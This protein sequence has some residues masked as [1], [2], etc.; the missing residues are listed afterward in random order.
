[1]GIKYLQVAS[2][3]TRRSI[4]KGILQSKIDKIKSFV[5]LDASSFG[6]NKFDIYN[7]T[8]RNGRFWESDNYENSTFSIIFNK[9]V[10][11]LH[12]IS[13]HSCEVSEC[14]A[15]F[16]VAGSNNGNSWEPICSIRRTNKTFMATIA[17]V[18][19]KS[20]FSY[21]MFK[22]KNIGINSS[23]N[24]VFTIHY[25]ELFGILF[26]LSNSFVTRCG[27][28]KHIFFSYNILLSLALIK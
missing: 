11:K 20:N 19:C 23:R 24:F 26:P 1:M 2:F 25:I 17:N 21:K 18:E 3:S 7:A 12:S 9:N 10:V 28:M 16:D 6:E 15:G 8:L 5:S 14:I 13:L 27:Q 4:E 22:L